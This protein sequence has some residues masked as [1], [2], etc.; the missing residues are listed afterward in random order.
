MRRNGLRAF[1]TELPGG[2][3]HYSYADQTVRKSA[4]VRY[5]EQCK[6]LISFEADFTTKCSSALITWE[7]NKPANFLFLF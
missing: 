4:L 6:Y 5:W 3:T 7:H 1:Y 2:E